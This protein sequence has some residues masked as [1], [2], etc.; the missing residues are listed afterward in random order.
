MSAGFLFNSKA[1]LSAQTSAKCDGSITVWK[2][3]V[4]EGIVK[5]ALLQTIKI[6]K[7]IYKCQYRG[8]GVP[9][10]FFDCVP[11]V[12]AKRGAGRHL[13]NPLA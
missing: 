9:D 4:Q 5:R 3:L 1:E 12:L 2:S 6:E 7:E 8:T 10:N 13:T 11:A